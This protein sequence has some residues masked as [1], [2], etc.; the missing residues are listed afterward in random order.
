MNKD[1]PYNTGYDKS[2]VDV[3]SDGTTQLTV[4]PTA[5]HSWFLPSYAGYRGG[6]RKKYFFSTRRAN[7]PQL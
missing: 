5:F 1:L 3:S 6:V 2:G 7:G 4:G